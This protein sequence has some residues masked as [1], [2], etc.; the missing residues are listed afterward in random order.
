MVA[1]FG[2]FPLMMW[3]LWGCSAY[4]GDGISREAAALLSQAKSGDIAAKFQIAAAYD[5][6]HGVSRNE[7]EAIRWYR[8]A[9]ESGYPEAQNSLGSILQAKKHYSEARGWY[10]KAADQDHAHATNNLA[11]LYDLGLGVSQDRQ[12]ALSLYAHAADLGWAA[13]MWNMANLYGA[14]Q[15]G[16]P[17]DLETACVWTYRAKKYSANSEHQLRTMTGDTLMKLERKLSAEQMSTCRDHGEMWSPASIAIRSDL[18][19]PAQ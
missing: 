1:R 10:E 16:G 2:R 12:K 4:A 15:L 11:Y 8:A 9:A 13:A 5:S 19:N 7:R 14:G 6:G 17:P 18:P 3:L